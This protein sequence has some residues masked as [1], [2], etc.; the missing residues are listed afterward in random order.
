MAPRR[1]E[2]LYAASCY[3]GIIAESI[4]KVNKNPHFRGNFSHFLADLS[5]GESISVW[6]R[7]PVNTPCHPCP[8]SHRIQA[9]TAPLG[10]I[11]RNQAAGAAGKAEQEHD[12][13]ADG[14]TAGRFC[15][16]IRCCGVDLF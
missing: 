14:D 15:D 9:L 6:G 2:S 12:Q 1:I 5:L 16:G 13:R 3:I 4:Q 7:F 11:E 10:K 8:P